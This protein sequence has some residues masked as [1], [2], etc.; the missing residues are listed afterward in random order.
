[1]ALLLSGIN[2]RE[3]LLGRRELLL[4][5][6]LLDIFADLALELFGAHLA[7]DVLVC[8]NRRARSE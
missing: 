1:L 6:P 4:A 5:L 8:Q 7:P 2:G 3:P